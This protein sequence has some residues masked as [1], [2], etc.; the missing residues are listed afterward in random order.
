MTRA[1]NGA[2]SA[3]PARASRSGAHVTERLRVNL[4]ASAEEAKRFR[5]AAESEGLP[6][7]QWVLEAAR[8]YELIGKSPNGELTDEDWRK[9][10][11]G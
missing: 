6:L 2:A 1:R 5:A 9:V 8:A 11:R 4:P 10:V 3:A 7:A